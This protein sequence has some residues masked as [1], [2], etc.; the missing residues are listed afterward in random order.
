MDNNLGSA[1]KIFAT[2]VGNR[3]SAVYLAMV[4]A[5]LAYAGI[6]MFVYGPDAAMAGVVP[7]LLT[8]PTSLALIGLPIVEAHAN[9]LVIVIVAALVNSTAIGLLA[10]RLGRPGRAMTLPHR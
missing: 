3:A 5:G 2:T 7:A 10:R 4:F 1:R 9:G 6:A 8:A